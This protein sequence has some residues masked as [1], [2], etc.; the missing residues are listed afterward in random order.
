[1]WIEDAGQTFEFERGE[2]WVF[3][4]VYNAIEFVSYTPRAA[5]DVY[6][7]YERLEGN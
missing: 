4:E 5:G 7:S 6:V 1:M 3:D 2:D